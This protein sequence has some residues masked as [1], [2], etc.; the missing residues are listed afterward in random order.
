MSGVRED[1][2]VHSVL[3]KDRIPQSLSVK[4]EKTTGRPPTPG[5]LLLC[6]IDRQGSVS[7]SV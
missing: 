5:P 6:D 1:S 4:G 2:R 3:P 7:L